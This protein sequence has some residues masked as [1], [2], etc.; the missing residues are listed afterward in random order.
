MRATC[1][2]HWLP[3]QIGGIIGF[4]TAWSANV[5]P[6]RRRSREAM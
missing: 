2:A 3:M 1:P 5:R 4:A 6:V